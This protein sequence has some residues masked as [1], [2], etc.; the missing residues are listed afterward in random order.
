MCQL[1][2][3]VP[4]AIASTDAAALY[5]LRVPPYPG[6]HFITPPVHLRGPHLAARVGVARWLGLD[7]GAMGS[8]P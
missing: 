2:R 4:A 5:S 7:L 1:F 8:P 6:G 3:G